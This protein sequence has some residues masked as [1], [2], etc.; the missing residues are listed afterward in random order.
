MTLE[1]SKPYKF[2]CLPMPISPLFQ[3][4][5]GWT[6]PGKFP[7]DYSLSSTYESCCVHTTRDAE[8][9]LRSHDNVVSTKWLLEKQ[10]VEAPSAGDFREHRLQPL[11]SFS[12]TRDYVHFYIQCMVFTRAGNL[13]MPIGF[14]D[15][16]FKHFNSSEWSKC[17]CPARV[18]VNFA[19]VSKLRSAYG[20]NAP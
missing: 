20:V 16:R 7:F 15:I 8:I 3:S 1:R 17:L 10:P 13:R 9:R 6:F 4:G 12:S 14:R 18:H 19:A 11:A 2:Q 5:C